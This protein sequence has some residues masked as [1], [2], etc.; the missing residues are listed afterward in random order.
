MNITKLKLSHSFVKIFCVFLLIIVYLMSYSIYLHEY[1]ILSSMSNISMDERVKN[2]ANNKQK[3][4]FILVS[5][6]E[7]EDED[8]KTRRKNNDDKINKLIGKLT[9]SF[10]KIGKIV[11]K[12]LD[13]MGFT[14][15]DVC[16]N[17]HTR[18]HVGYPVSRY[19]SSDCGLG[20]IGMKKYKGNDDEIQNYWIKV[21]DKRNINYVKS[22]IEMHDVQV[23]YITQLNM[24]INYALLIRKKDIPYGYVRDDIP[25][26]IKIIKNNLI[27]T[28]SVNLMSNNDIN[29]LSHNSKS[30]CSSGFTETDCGFPSING[31]SIDCGNNKIGF[32][33]KCRIESDVEVS[34]IWVKIAMEENNKKKLVKRISDIRDNDGNKLFDVMFIEY[35]S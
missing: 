4:Y 23:K 16:I 30:I 7:S 22:Q 9:L 6:K 17:G 18:T 25:D 33:K 5:F 27:D 3:K 19:S 31:S 13:L 2:H 11:N 21:Y 8:L 35:I 1:E 34:D 12:D 14:G 24:N 32:F 26:V 29:K 15:K 10:N 28:K 20:M